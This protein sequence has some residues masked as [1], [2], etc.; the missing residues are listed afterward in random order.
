[1]GNGW[2]FHTYMDSVGEWGWQLVSSNG[3]IG[4]DSGEGYG[5]LQGVRDAA[6]RVKDNAGGAT[7]D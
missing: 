5:S 7:T 1:M 6:Q 4:A 2:N 3:R